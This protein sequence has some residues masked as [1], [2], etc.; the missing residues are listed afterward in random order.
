MRKFI[1]ISIGASVL[2]AI[3]LVKLILFVVLAA[4]VGIIR[5]IKVFVG[6]IQLSDKGDSH[7]TTH[8]HLDLPG[9]A[10]IDFGSGGGGT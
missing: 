10:T 2:V 7:E 4:V 5:V 9:L 1:C 8:Y 6:I 3:F